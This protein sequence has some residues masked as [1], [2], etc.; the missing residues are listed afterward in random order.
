MDFWHE[1]GQKKL[2][3]QNSIKGNTG[4][5]SRATSERALGLAFTRILQDRVALPR[6]EIALLDF[7]V[8]AQVF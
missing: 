5:G 7:P 4:Q 6:L 8:D 3:V 1:I 2:E